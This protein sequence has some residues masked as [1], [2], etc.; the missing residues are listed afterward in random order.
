M[1]CK[2]V[3]DVDA[4]PV[5]DILEDAE[6]RILAAKAAALNSTQYPFLS[7]LY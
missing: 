5:A 2:R 4:A 3:M 6:M 7:N 1:T